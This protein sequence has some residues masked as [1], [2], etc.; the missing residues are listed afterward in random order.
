[1]QVKV[2]FVVITKL[3]FVSTHSYHNERLHVTLIQAS[4]IQIVNM[5]KT[6]QA[7]AINTISVNQLRK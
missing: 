4:Y 1:M 5:E 3:S 6:T 7:T 2:I